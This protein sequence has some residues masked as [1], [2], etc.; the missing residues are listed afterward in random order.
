MF[1]ADLG[2]PI[3]CV[4]V[5]DFGCMAGTV[6]GKVMLYNFQDGQAE[7]LTAFS[8]E[9]VRG[10]YMD[11]EVAYATLMDLCKGWNM[12]P[13]HQQSISVNFRNW[14]RKNSQHVKHILQRGPW[15][16]V[17]FP[18]ASTVMHIPRQEHHQ[19]S[20]RLFDYGGTGSE[21]A[22]CDFDGE[23]LVLVDRSAGT[24]PPI[25]R[26][27]Q[28]ERNEHLE[29]EAMPKASMASV[30]RLWCGSYLVY[31]VDSSLLVYD[32]RDKELKATIT[33][34]RAEI[35]AV[36]TQDPEIL[37]TLARDASVK[38]WNGRTG[39]CMTTVHFEDAHYFMEYPYCLSVSGHRILVSADEGVFLTELEQTPAVP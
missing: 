4:Y 30:I 32:Y 1:Q 17:V 6:Q 9:G 15:A 39:Q 8:D 28:L 7:V 29:I 36:D 13:P 25:F 18:M 10:L 22:P 24:G 26:V 2:D 16:C 27:V 38:L 34:H 3:S 11:N 14:D 12:E 19:R 5:N 37:A 20:L 35:V 31:S 23:T 21:V 33:G